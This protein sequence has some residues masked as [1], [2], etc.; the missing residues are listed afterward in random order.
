MES[1]ITYRNE[2]FKENIQPIREKTEHHYNLLNEATLKFISTLGDIEKRYLNSQETPE[3]LL[4]AI[5]MATT[6]INH[7]CEQFERRVGHDSD[8]IKEARIEFRKK[9]DHVLSN[10]YVVN[11]TRTWPQGYQGDYKTLEFIYRNSPQSEGIGYYLDLYC[12]NATVA[13]AVRNRI[14]TLESIL[15]EEIS[16]RKRPAVLNVACGSC[17]ELMGLSDVIINSNAKVT[18][19]D[20]DNDALDFAQSRLYHTGALPQIELRKYNAAR[21]FDHELNMAAFGKQDIIYSVGYFD[22]LE[23]DFLVKM[24]SS[25]YMLL[26]PDGKL[27]MTFKDADYYKTQDYHWL[28]DWDGFLQRNENDFKRILKKA[29]IPDNALSQTRDKSGVI[30]FC[31][32]TK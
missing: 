24:L 7:V 5:T 9:T 15:K 10:S 32:A 4:N 6:N 30:I 17:R 28:I 19:I 18:C 8:I 25:L 21:M 31:T 20:F 14:K 27:I 29:W 3:E 1:L 11:R 23:T 22:Y 12:L 13:H 26:N 16:M 2:A